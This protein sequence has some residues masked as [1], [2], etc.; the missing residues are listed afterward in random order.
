MSE[1]RFQA[2]LRF[3]LD[4]VALGQVLLRT[5]LC[6]SVMVIILTLCTYLH[7]NTTVV[8]KTT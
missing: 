1:V 4:K 2:S 6:S 8:R 5:L 7:L 3:E